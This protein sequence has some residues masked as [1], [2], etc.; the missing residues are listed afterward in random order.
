[1]RPTPVLYKIFCDFRVSTGVEL[2]PNGGVTKVNP[3]ANVPRSDLSQVR[4]GS[5]HSRYP[6]DAEDAAD[7]RKGDFASL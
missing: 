4:E 1:M 2:D 7:D 5:Q 6:T 3:V